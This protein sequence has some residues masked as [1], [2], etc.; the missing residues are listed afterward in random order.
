MN[1][2]TLEGGE[3]LVV[4]NNFTKHSLKQQSLRTRILTRIPKEFGAYRN[5]KNIQFSLLI[6]IIILEK[7]FNFVHFIAYDVASG[8]QILSHCL[9]RKL[10]LNTGR[11]CLKALSV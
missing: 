8:F 5:I 9:S 1:K 7:L 10:I 11:C 3:L 4:G 6:I 2:G